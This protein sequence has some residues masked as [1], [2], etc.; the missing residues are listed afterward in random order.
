MSQVRETLSV[1]SVVS[2][3]S[4]DHYR[5][6]SVLGCGG[7]STIYLVRDDGSQSLYALKEVLSPSRRELEQ[8]TFEYELLTRLEHPSLPHVYQVFTDE[9]AHHTYILM[10]YIEGMNGEELR[11]QY[12]ASRIPLSDVLHIMTPIMEA[13]RFLHQQKPPVLHRDIKP[14]NIIVPLSGETAY[15]VDFGTAKRYAS[16]ATTTAVRHFTPGYGAPEQYAMGTMPSTDIY[17][18]GATFYT[19]LTGQIPVEALERMVQLNEES[20]DPLIPLQELVPTLPDGIAEAIHHAMSLR[21]MERFATVDE[22]QQALHQESIQQDDC[23]IVTKPLPDGNGEISHYSIALVDISEP[24][25]ISVPSPVSERAYTSTSSKQNKHISLI[26]LSVI[27]LC[28]IGIGGIYQLLATHR[29]GNI[30]ISMT[31][32]SQ[33]TSANHAPT[34]TSHT[35]TSSPQSTMPYAP[36]ATQYRGTVSDIMGNTT[37]SMSLDALQQKSNVLHGDFTGL[38]LA[39]TFAGTL[40]IAGHLQFQVV[41]HGGNETLQFEGAVKVGGTMAGSYRIVNR[42]HEFTGE[43]GLWSVSPTNTQ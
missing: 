20:S 32:H 28:V 41:I 31:Q 43:Y 17:G 21:R 40:D 23:I 16:E 39:G 5:I 27:L 35:A 33:N 4:R 3:S 42:N 19:L 38:G 15:L 36:L 37:T 2:G 25:P 26:L 6:E 1:G 18:L 8:L 11:K 34:S 24:E 29:V 30:G 7:F 22:F 12:P 9:T 13:V 10:E 14:S